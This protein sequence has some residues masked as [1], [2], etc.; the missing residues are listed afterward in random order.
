MEGTVV[1]TGL[2][3]SAILVI[4]VPHCTW[5]FLSLEPLWGFIGEVSYP[6]P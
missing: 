6:P 1:D 4:S 5:L 3:L 2:F